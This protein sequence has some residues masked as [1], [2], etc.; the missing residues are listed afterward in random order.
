MAVS[1]N[2]HQPPKRGERGDAMVGQYYEGIEGIDV[3]SCRVGVDVGLTEAW[4]K[5]FVISDELPRSVPMDGTMRLLDCSA[6]R[7]R[8]C[9]LR[10]L[11]IAKRRE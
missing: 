9:V 8:K 2:A 7:T 1:V 5:I 6:H 10:V 3:A 4:T 11:R